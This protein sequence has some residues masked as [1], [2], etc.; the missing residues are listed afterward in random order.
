MNNQW[1]YGGLHTHSLPSPPTPVP[2]NNPFSTNYIWNWNFWA[3]KND[4]NADG[5]A[6]EGGEK[7]S[8]WHW[9]VCRLSC[10]PQEDGGTVFL[11]MAARQ[12]VKRWLS[13]TIHPRLNK[14][15]CYVL[16]TKGK[17]CF[18]MRCCPACIDTTHLCT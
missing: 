8:Q 1:F 14:R 12:V 11:G 9:S 7:L 5:T 6:L 13:I 15:S 3:E 4:S 2:D 10:L 16:S 17:L 18:L